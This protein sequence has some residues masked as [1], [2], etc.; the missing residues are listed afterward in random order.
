MDMLTSVV[1]AGNY[2]ASNDVAGQRSAYMFFYM[3]KFPFVLLVIYYTFLAY[4]E[5]KGLY[6]EGCANAGV[7]GYG[8][9]DERSVRR[10]EPQAHNVEPFQGTGYRLG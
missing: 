8:T 3:V 1:V 7:G 5:L 9:T 4:R 6:I 10:A 2:F